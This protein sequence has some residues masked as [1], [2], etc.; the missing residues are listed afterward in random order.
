VLVFLNIWASVIFIFFSISQT[1]LV[2]YILPMYPPL[3]M[4]VGWYIDR[5]WAKGI[6]SGS[7]SWSIVLAILAIVFTVGMVIGV[8]AMPVLQSGVYLSSAIFITMAIVVAYFLWNK[9]IGNAFWT[10]IIAMGLFSVVLVS[11][12]FPAAAPSFTMKNMAKEFNVKYDGTSPVYIIKFLHPGF[13]FYTDIYGTEVKM[14]NAKKT[15]SE[16][17][18]SI[19]DSR[20][21]YFVIRHADYQQLADSER[22]VLKV[23]VDMDE[24]LMLLK[25]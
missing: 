6:Q 7:R 18:K 16:L 19:Q 20:R 1:K 23:L 10:Q 9:A 21:A 14:D 25:E 24:K 12:L 15:S 22:K 17:T 11:V 2:S 8:K 5:L 13:T 3:A 4:I